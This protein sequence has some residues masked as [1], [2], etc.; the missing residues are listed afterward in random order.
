MTEKITKKVLADAM[1]DLKV[2]VNDEIEAIKNA[3][4]EHDESL[5]ISL[6]I[7][8]GE[9]TEGFEVKPAMSFSKG[10]VTRQCK[11][12]YNAQMKLLD[13]E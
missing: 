4:L 1:E 13:I 12:V 8:L 5:K 11:K 6:S 7:T 2:Y 3:Y 10:K 9:G